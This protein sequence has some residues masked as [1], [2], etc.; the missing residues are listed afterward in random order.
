MRALTY[1]DLS[2]A[3]RA[4]KRAYRWKVSPSRFR[5]VTAMRTLR[6]DTQAWLRIDWRTT[7]T[8]ARHDHHHRNSYFRRRGRTRFRRAV[9]SVHDDQR[10]VRARRQ[11]SSARC[12]A[13]R[14]TRQAV[15][16]RQGH[17]RVA[18]RDD[19]EQPAARRAAYSGRA[20]HPPGGEER[21]RCSPGSPP[22]RPSANGS[23]VCVRARCCSPRPDPRKASA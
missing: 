9:G 8:K 11:G 22:P 6:A 20:R 1:P 13:R 5:S 4:A 7:G 12:A 3:F 16:L 21:S 18:G 10:V 17:A 2:P 19:C 23:R 14:R 15:S